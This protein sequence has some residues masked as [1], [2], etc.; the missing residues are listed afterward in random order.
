MRQ[1]V[2][3]F[4]SSSDLTSRYRPGEPAPEDGPAFEATALPASERREIAATIPHGE[5]RWVFRQAIGQDERGYWIDP[6]ARANRGGLD[7]EDVRIVRL[8]DGTFEVDVSRLAHQIA[9]RDPERHVT[10]TH[11]AGRE[12]ERVL[13]DAYVAT[14]LEITLRGGD[15]VVVEPTT[16]G[17]VRGQFPPD[18]THI[19]VLTASN[20]CTH[21][22]TPDEN[23]SRNL[24]LRDDLL[25][26]DTE[27]TEAVGRSLDGSWS[28]A[29]FAVF[30]GHEEA[31]IELA[32]QYGQQAV[33]RWEARRR[34][35][36]YIS[37]GRQAAHGWRAAE[38]SNSP[39]SDG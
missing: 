16:D 7:A 38:A 13:H 15:R 9:P 26:L 5:L 14:V 17:S 30:D 39:A 8:D 24:R 27:F 33:F 29:S 11:V 1:L 25:A 20:P 12:I 2:R 19:H 10:L 3:L 35:V 28:E 37:S 23:E 32:R 4:R 36:R 31:L 18:L 6:A 22:T 21:L 34:L